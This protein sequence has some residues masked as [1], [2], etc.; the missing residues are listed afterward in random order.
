MAGGRCCCCCC[1]RARAAA[2]PAAAAEAAEAAASKHA[3][4]PPPAPPS[5]PRGAENNAD[6]DNGPA[7]PPLDDRPPPGPDSKVLRSALVSIRGDDDSA[8]QLEPRV[9][10]L[11]RRVVAWRWWWSGAVFTS[12]NVTSP[13]LIT[14]T[15]FAAA[16][17]RILPPPGAVTDENSSWGSV[18]SACRSW[19]YCRPPFNPRDGAFE[20]WREETLPAK[21]GCLRFD[22]SIARRAEVITVAHHSATIKVSRK[23]GTQTHTPSLCR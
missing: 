20:L 3:G 13:S 6:G 23:T 14:R 1:W 9:P 15:G 22:G 10:T 19:S 21:P 5:G 16:S 17:R 4:P 7:P 11:G 8:P 2:A 12:M 18:R